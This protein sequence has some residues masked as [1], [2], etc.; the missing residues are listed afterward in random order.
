[1]LLASLC[2]WAVQLSFAST[3]NCLLLWLEKLRVIILYSVHFVRDKSWMYPSTT[4]CFSPTTWVFT[5]FLSTNCSYNDPCPLQFYDD[6]HQETKQKEM[7]PN[8]GERKLRLWKTVQAGGRSRT[9]SSCC[10]K[11][12]RVE[13]G[14]ELKKE[15]LFRKG[16][17]QFVNSVFLVRKKYR[18]WRKK[19]TVTVA[20]V[21]TIVLRF[22]C[23]W[24]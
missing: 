11:W 23:G 17:L 9:T 18:L 13:K 2:I 5:S 8:W 15:D 1:M 16:C 12:K 21:A 3:Q 4:C 22:S 20:P 7:P 24:S 10:W 14:L 19:R 6:P